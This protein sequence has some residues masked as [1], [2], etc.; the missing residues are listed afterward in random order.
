MV[1]TKVVQRKPICYSSIARLF[2]SSILD[3]FATKG[4]SQTASE[5]VSAS[6]LE[7]SID[8]FIRLDEF[9]DRMYLH[10]FNNYRNEYVYKNAL[11]EKLLLG[12]HSLNTSFML[13]EFRSGCCKA[14]VVLLNGTSH[15]FEIKTQYD[16]L[17]RLEKQ[18]ATYAKQFN[19]IHVLTH[20]CMLDKV[21]M[22]VDD[23]I[24]LMILSDRYTLRQVRK[25]K[26]V[27]NQTR[28]DKIFDSLRKSEY[29]NI[30]KE[31]YGFTPDVPNTQAYKICKKLFCKLNPEIAHDTMVVELKKRGENN[32]V[33]DLVTFAPASLKSL[34]L[35]SRFK[36][37]TVKKLRTI[38]QS[39]IT[40][41]LSF[42]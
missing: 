41:F 35:S 19:Y 38:F 29:L 25:P 3:E 36:S 14:D 17:D 30:V 23:D 26:S 1:V 5:I 18:I 24:G 10:L 34:M 16:S 21:S 11:V 40:D 6:D 27:K 37:S 15:V 8:K 42:S 20:E 39:P 31:T 28:Q 12:K 4:W 2:S 7:C 33:K 13:T 9:Y 32:N 22:L